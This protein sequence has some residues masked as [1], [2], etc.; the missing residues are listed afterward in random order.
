MLTEISKGKTQAKKVNY[1]SLKECSLYSWVEVAL[2]DINE[3]K[4]ISDTFKTAQ[5][6]DNAKEITRK[7][8]R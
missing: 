4:N 2:Q 6:K 5:F 7:Y 8:A 1:W 3:N